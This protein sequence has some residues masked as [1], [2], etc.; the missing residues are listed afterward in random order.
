MAVITATMAITL[1]DVIVSGLGW[2]TD[3]W[4]AGG[5]GNSNTNATVGHPATLAVQLDGVQV[6]SAVVSGHNAIIGF[7][8]DDVLVAITATNSAIPPDVAAVDY[9]IEIRSFTERR[10]I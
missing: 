10:R 1:D 2:G 5:W 6:S 4:G 7:T 8:L 3:P 9:F